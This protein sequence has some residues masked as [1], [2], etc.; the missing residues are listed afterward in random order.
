MERVKITPE[1]ESPHLPS[2]NPL[3]REGYYFNGYDPKS[4]TGISVKIEIKPVLGFRQEFV[5]VHGE[6]PFL[7]LNARKIEPGNAL[8]LGSLKAEPV[9]PLKKW[10]IEMKDTFQKVVDGI[11]S[12]ISKE[13]GFNLVF[14]SD[15]LP[16]GYAAEEG[17][18]YE[19]PGFL[20]GEIT[21]DSNLIPFTG[22][23]IRDHSW[24]IR[25]VSTWG[26][27]YMLTGWYGLKPLSFAYTQ[28]DDTIDI[29]GW[30]KTDDY[31]EIRTIQI[32]PCRSG[33][34]IQECTMKIETG[35][36]QIE[37]KSQ[38]VSFLSLPREEKGR[39]IRV[40]ETLVEL[41]DGYAFFWYGE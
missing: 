40:I 12:A 2:E 36:N 32:D 18:R 10:R 35:Q 31:E 13:V 27:F 23:S 38:L 21:I 5:S 20:E 30:L 11:P 9:L 1:N 26:K 14:R 34:I 28:V 15:I 19:Q 8:T 7:F 17:I 25:D 6:N 29:I 39:K 24:G 16:C 3:W 41:E 4:K 33:D 22:K 37:M